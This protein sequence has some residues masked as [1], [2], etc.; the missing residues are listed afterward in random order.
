MMRPFMALNGKTLHCTS[1]IYIEIL[2]R[3]VSNSFAPGFT[4]VAK[5]IEQKLKLRA[6]DSGKCRRSWMFARLVCL[7]ASAHRQTF[8]V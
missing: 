6:S 3:R 1:A 5:T 2:P 7:L 8:L 4:S